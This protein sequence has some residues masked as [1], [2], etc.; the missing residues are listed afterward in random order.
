MTQADLAE[1]AGV[2]TKWIYRVE[3]ASETIELGRLLRVL[4]ALDFSVRLD[5]TDVATSLGGL[6]D[7]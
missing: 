3:Q 5:T 7:G 2:S 1:R 6:V 4:R